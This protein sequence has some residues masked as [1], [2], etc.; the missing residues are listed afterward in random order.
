VP[1]II[2]RNDIV[3]MR[4]DAIVNST[5]VNLKCAGM[6]VDA[7]IHQAAGPDLQ[8]ACDAIGHCELG[9]AV[10]TPGFDLPGK[11]VIHT[12]GPVWQGGRKGEKELLKSCYR[13]I[14]ALAAENKLKSVAM[15][16]I[17]AGAYGYP[18]K[19]ALEVASKE[20]RRFLL[21]H[22]DMTVYIVIYNSEML[23]ISES[24]FNDI[25][26]YIDNNYIDMR[27]KSLEETIAPDDS[28]VTWEEERLSARPKAMRR[29]AVE[30]DETMLSETTVRLMNNIAEPDAEEYWGQDSAPKVSLNIHKAKLDAKI[31]GLG[32]GA[33]PEELLDESF[34]QAIMRK[35]EMKGVKKFSTYYSKANITKAVF[36]KIRTSAELMTAYNYG[37]KLT[38]E[39]MKK[40]DYRPNKNTAIALC[41]A[42]ELELPDFL[43][44]LE[45]AGYTL[46]YSVLFDVIIRYFVENGNYD[47][48]TINEMLFKY[49]QA[50]L[51][52]E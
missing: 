37:R 28:R 47:I 52:Q 45:K 27:F 6:G 10:I 39:E 44:T 13:S 42:L 8:K 26:Q 24:M 9:G 41:V 46:S 23:T 38:P 21:T 35:L 25:T 19:E 43:R 16:V 33:S 12:A 48:F 51:G 15:P 14:L 40:K 17:S 49:D 2:V 7:Y 31:A 34:N 20:I 22:D 5:N 29:E 1:L 32:F 3:T 36:S 18:K 4:V 11:Y 50:L 30:L